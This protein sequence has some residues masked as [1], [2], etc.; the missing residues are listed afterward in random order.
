MIALHKTGKL[1]FSL[2]PRNRSILRA[3]SHERPSLHNIA[4]EMH[5]YEGGGWIFNMSLM[6]KVATDSGCAS[7][8]QYFTNVDTFTRQLVNNL[9]RGFPTIIGF[10]NEPRKMVGFRKGRWAHYGVVIQYRESKR[11]GKPLVLLMDGHGKQNWVPISMLFASNAQ[12]YKSGFFTT[13]RGPSLEHGH[14]VEDYSESLKHKWADHDKCENI[15]FLYPTS[16][17]GMVGRM[18]VVTGEKARPKL[19]VATHHDKT[20]YRTALLRGL[21]PSCVPHAAP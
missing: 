9:H 13:A 1:S 14:A 18:L 8:F 19:P 7:K 21:R 2:P 15:A 5:G 12:L 10:D 6:Q 20:P 17:A 3:H 11:T 16:C 4:R